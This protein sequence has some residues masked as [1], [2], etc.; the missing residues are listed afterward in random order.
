MIIKRQWGSSRAKYGELLIEGIIKEY[1]KRLT[2]EF[3]K[4]YTPTRLRYFRR[5]YQVFSKCPT[6][7]D[8][9][10]FSHYCEI[11]WF[12]ENKMN[13]YIDIS[14][15][16]SLS[17]RELRLKIKNKEYERLPDSTKNKLIKNE[18]TS[19]KDFVKEPI[20]IKVNSEYKKFNEKVL[21]KIILED[22]TSFLKE[23]DSGFSY[24][25]H[26]YKIKM[27]NNY[28]YIDFL[29][30]NI[31]YNCYAVVEL[32]VVNLKKEHIGQIEV[33]MNYIDKNIKSINH[34]KTI[35][36]IMVKKNN[37]LIME[38]S[39]DPRIISREYIVTS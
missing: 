21:Q 22:I 39:S 26:E 27:G 28:N 20:I 2:N 23:L 15:N 14:I 10:T 3:G 7:S 18:D 12:D 8:V 34:D 6:L 13:F 17:V 25:D 32:K 35:G 36:I 33:Y 1:S 38:Y 30:F 29:L 19:L 31:K 4:G 16:Q 9:L 5:F 37:E 24:I 11:I